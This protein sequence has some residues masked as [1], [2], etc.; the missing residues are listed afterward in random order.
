MQKLSGDDARLRVLF[1]RKVINDKPREEKVEYL[2]AGG[3]LTDR[4]YEK[5]AEV[6]RQVLKPGQKMN[7]LKL[8][9]GPFPL[10]LG[11]DK[12][13]V[14]AMF[15]VSKINPA[16][17]DPPGTIHMKLTPKTG[18]QFERKFASIEFWVDLQSRMPVKIVTDDPNGTTQ[19]TTT[20][21][22]VR[23]NTDLTDKDFQLPPINE[24]EWD[25]RQMQ[26]E[27]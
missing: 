5:H 7:L 19:R 9:E 10:P 24:K 8:G 16:K 15:E 11:Q 20:L 25:R 21:T 4:D 22:D 13:D 26:Y 27:E 23:V 17:D 18:S 3:M 1:D 14:H 2:L 6:Q 12:K